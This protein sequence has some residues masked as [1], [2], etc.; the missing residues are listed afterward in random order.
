MVACHVLSLPETF[1]PFGTLSDRRPLLHCLSINHVGVVDIIIHPV[2]LCHHVPVSKVL[3]MRVIESRW[4]EAPCLQILSR[5]RST[6]PDKM[7]R[8]RA[9][10]ASCLLFLTLKQA[11]MLLPYLVDLDTR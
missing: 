8:G 7:A 2:V 4:G 1:L 10:N 3:I 9:S 11:Q 5:L 6:Q